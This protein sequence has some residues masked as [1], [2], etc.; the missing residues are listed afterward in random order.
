M[1]RLVTALVLVLY[2]CYVF[3]GCTTTPAE[4]PEGTKQDTLTV[5]FQEE[6]GNIDP[7][8]KPGLVNQALEALVY[9]SLITRAD[10]G[11]YQPCL[12]TSWEII[13]E[14]TIRFYLRD[15]VYFHNG[16]KF[17]S[18]DVLYTIQRGATSPNIANAFGN[19]DGENSA[20]VDEYTFDLKL[21]SPFAPIFA[22]LATARGG[23]LNQKAV[24]EAG[25]AY[26][27]NPVGTGCMI[28]K[29]W[30]S[31]DHITLTRNENYWG[32]KPVYTT[33]NAR[34]ISDASNRAIEVETGGADIALHINTSDIERLESN[35]NTY[36]LTGPSTCL[37]Y[38]CFD[39]LYSDTYDNI[40]VRQALSA[41]L[42]RE[43]I[44]HAVFGGDYGS[45]ADS[46]FPMST[47]YYVSC[48]VDKYDP[49]LAEKLLKEANFDTSKEIV[50]TVAS[51]SDNLA[52]AEIAQ[53]MWSAV[54]LNVKI[55]PMETA[56]FKENTY[57]EAG[58]MPFRITSGTFASGDPDECLTV[59]K[60]TDNVMHNNQEWWDLF[61]EAASVYD[62]ESRGALYQEIQ[63]TIVDSR[64]YIPLVYTSAVY[65]VRDNIEGLECNPAYLPDFSA[66]TFK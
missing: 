41:A 36:A 58:D 47:T 65:A 13:D 44:A 24:E 10:D 59:L 60:R 35:E 50:L 63:N 34:V 52:I 51:T 8:E 14:L 43:A 30:V 45:A 64:V 32:D 48:D 56:A 26:A 40:K 12:A 15:D 3:C 27:R 11:S 21:K 53:N 5:V 57:N 2:C 20:C 7:H 17:T 25:D 55:V 46:I 66:V 31:G 16:E 23:M 42:D 29:E 1:K 19:C 6:P 4:K 54:G 9:D 18:A 37:I 28:F 49:A 38:M 39:T 61:A 33:F 22:W 62:N